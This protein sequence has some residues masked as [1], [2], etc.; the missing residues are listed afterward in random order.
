MIT[1]MFTTMI[2]RL[3]SGIKVMKNVRLKKQRLRKNYCP[4]LGTPIV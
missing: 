2:M 4:L 3:L 1:I